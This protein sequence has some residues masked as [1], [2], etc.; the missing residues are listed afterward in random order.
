MALRLLHSWRLQSTHVP[1]KRWNAAQ[2]NSQ[3]GSVVTITRII[4][5]LG[6]AAFSLLA[7]EA[8]AYADNLGSEPNGDFYMWGPWWADAPNMNPSAPPANEVIGAWLSEEWYFSGFGNQTNNDI[9]TFQGPSDA[10]ALPETDGLPSYLDN[11]FNPPGTD[12]PVEPT[13]DTTPTT[14][15]N[16]PP[17]NGYSGGNYLPPSTTEEP[18]VVTPEP[19]S[20]LLLGTGLAGLGFIRHRT[21]SNSSRK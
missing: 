9:P 12:S 17:P 7:A 2:L 15:D 20:L 21:K 11:I 16:T 4:C 1:W 19:G 18:P 8:P 3:G 5:L 14:E 10:P 6:F 13:G